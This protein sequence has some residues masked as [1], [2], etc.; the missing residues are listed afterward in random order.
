MRRRSLL[1]FT[2]AVAAAAL[3]AGCGGSTHAAGTPALSFATRSTRL[4]D[5]TRPPYITG[6]AVNP[7]NGSVL[8]A[9]NRGIYRTAASGRGLSQVAAKA[10]AGSHV[11]DYGERVSSFAYIDG[12]KLIGSGHPSANAKAL[13]PFLGV[14]ESEDEGREWTATARVGY[15]D[16]HVI[17]VSGSTV[18]GFDT[19]LGGV[20]AS[21]DGGRSFTERT[22][23]PGPYV[24]DLAID[25][26]AKL[27]LLASTADA[28][29]SSRDGGNTWQQISAAGQAHMAWNAHGLYRA[30]ADRSVSTS[31]D[32]GV[33]W[34]VVGRLPG[35]PGK[36]VETAAGTLYA[37]LTEGTVVTSQNG[38]RSWSTLFSP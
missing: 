33:T 14:M 20:V 29:F 38:G 4:V 24:L 3:L 13:P 11:G 12:T 16:L 17:V 2:C 8:L 10:R 28:I 1:G 22:A 6:L 30:D 35:L 23:P 31:S 19:I 37:A 26:A 27:H 9:T 15:S 21:Y 18:Y 34:H 25:P 36:L 32:G 5:A 7:V